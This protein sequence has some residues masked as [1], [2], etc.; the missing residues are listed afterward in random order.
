M[1]QG[2]GFR[3]QGSGFN[4]G[5]RVQGSGF[6]VYGLGFRVEGVALVSN[7]TPGSDKSNRP[8]RIEA[9]EVVASPGR[10]GAW[11]AGTHALRHA[12]TQDLE[13]GRRWGLGRRE[14]PLDPAS[15]RAGKDN[16]PRR[17]QFLT[18]PSLH[19]HVEMRARASTW[20]PSGG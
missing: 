20:F 14:A 3:G 15:R 11:Q 19:I 16:P 6:R 8:L 13:G 5:F 2:S 9:L 4:S 10:E 7:L 12:G 17:C 18:P 1:I